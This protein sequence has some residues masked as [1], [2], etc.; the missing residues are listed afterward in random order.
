MGWS[1]TIG[2]IAGTDIRLHF[3][4]LLFL[5][6]IGIADYLQ[7]GL[8][9]AMD[10]VAFILL[11]FLCVTLHEF[12]HIAMARRFGIRTPQVILSPIGG[13]ASM[14]RMPERPRQELLVAIAGPL[15]NVVIALLLV[16]GFG[17]AIG[18]ITSID[19]EA[20][21]LAE[22]LLIVNV[23][24]VLFNMVPAFP[25]DGGRVL[26][27]VLAMNM[28]PARATALAARIG[29]GF[30]FLFVLLGLFY[31][32]IL[33]FVGIFIYLAAASEEQS[34]AFTGFA[35]KLRVRDAMEPSPIL[36]AADEPLSKAI[37]ALLS[38]PQ[39]EFPVLDAVGRVAGLLDRDAMILGLRDHGA[40]AAVGSAM[41]PSVPRI[42]RPAPGGRFRWHAHQ[43]RQGRGGARLRRKRCRRPHPG[44]HRRN[45][46]GR[47]RPAGLALRETMRVTLV[48]VLTGAKSGDNAQVLRAA[49]AM[50][51]PFTEKR[52]VLNPGWE[53]A[54]P[55]VEPSLSI[56]DQSASDKLE[57]PWPDLVITIGRRLSLPALW[58]KE[59]SGG[60]TKLALFNAPKGRARDFDLVVVPAFYAMEDGPRVCRIGL[61]LIAADPVRIEAARQ[62]FASDLSKLARPLHVLLLGGDMGARKLDARFATKTLRM[63]QEGFARTGSVF[64]S[65]SRR[66]PAA[67]ADAVEGL[68]RP[69]DRLYRW[70]QNAG[71]NPYL[72][73]LAHGD[74]FTVTSDSLSMLTEVARLGRPLM[75]AEPQG[76]PGIWRQLTAFLSAKP[77]RD[78]GEATS[79][80]VKGGHA[81]RLGDP[82]PEVTKLPADDTERV[83]S[84]L[85][86]LASDHD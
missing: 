25:M 78:L 27:A 40:A 64:V 62:D 13:I 16:A 42:S 51:L 46:D 8:A 49:T 18:Q 75:I 69:Q 38:S 15:V 17:I 81:V 43:K 61:P 59:Q 14:E 9:A 66:T 20:A 82:L 7:G 52:I 32:P 86:N 53:T 4:F 73:L 72:G 67:A 74:T 39:K 77:A 35:S 21:S 1:L 23:M 30:A 41:R 70:Q 10:S 57:A 45:D 22:R 85:R 11:V 12:G 34:A 79:F 84:R 31:N 71:R 29:Q 63:M 37:D 58:I 80:L 19:F 5:A 44:K 26:R 28:G 36:L 55:K 48:W 83:A 6:W 3:T 68:L 76:Q 56:V 54:K 47:K 33:M 60:R 50:G 65:T 24:L 2:R